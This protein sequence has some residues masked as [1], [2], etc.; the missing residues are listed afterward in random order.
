MTT[1]GIRHGMRVLDVGCSLT[2]DLRLAGHAPPPKEVVVIKVFDW[3]LRVV[4]QDGRVLDCEHFEWVK[5]DG[6]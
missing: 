5:K 4:G 6:E 3:G 2:Q 1:L